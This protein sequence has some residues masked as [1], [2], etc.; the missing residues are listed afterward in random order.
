MYQYHTRNIVIIASVFLDSI[1]QGVVDMVLKF[2]KVPV[3]Y[4]DHHLIHG[5]Y[6]QAGELLS[7]LLNARNNN[8]VFSHLDLAGL[9]RM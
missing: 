1:L 2:F 8:M 9:F 7:V 5:Q 3:P 4:V 6:M